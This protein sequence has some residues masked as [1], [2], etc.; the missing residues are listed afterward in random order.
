VGGEEKISKAWMKDGA[1]IEYAEK[2]N[3]MCFQ[4]EHR[5]YGQSYPTE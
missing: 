1:M 5:Y 3:A 2:F 4:L